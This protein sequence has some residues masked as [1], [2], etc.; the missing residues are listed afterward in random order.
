MYLVYNDS[1]C[2]VDPICICSSSSDAEEMCLA[3]AEETYYHHCMLFLQVN[4]PTFQTL[5]TMG[6]YNYKEV[7]FVG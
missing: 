3:L 5:I 7:P 4:R 1:Y 6:H 2:E